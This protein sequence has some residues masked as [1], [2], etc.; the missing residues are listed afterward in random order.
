MLSE[1]DVCYIDTRNVLLAHIDNQQLPFKPIAD[2]ILASGFNPEDKKN[3]FRYAAW[4]NFFQR[5]AEKTGN[6]INTDTSDID[7]ANEVFEHLFETIKPTYVIFVSKKAWDCSGALRHKCKDKAIVFDY[8]PHPNTSW[9][10]RKAKPY[11]D[12][13]GREKFEDFL[14]QNKIFLED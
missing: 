13:T 4:C 3:M 10:N 14:I 1:D 8:A 11:G 5:P 7:K 9:W 6:S 12:M 2:A